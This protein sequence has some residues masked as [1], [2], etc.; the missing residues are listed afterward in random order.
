MRLNDGLPVWHVSL[1]LWTPTQQPIRAPGRL[2]RI[3]VSMLAPVGGD[4]E[5][6][7]WNPRAAVGHL[8]V[9]VTAAE[10]EQIPPGCALDDAG[11]SGPPR[12]RTRARRPYDH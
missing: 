5:W 4:T 7:L 2:E 10:Y 3:A 11:E 8:R 9:A 12:R 1:S 6:W